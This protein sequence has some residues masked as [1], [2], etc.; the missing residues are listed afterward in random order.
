[1][2]GKLMANDASNEPA[3]SSGKG[4]GKAVDG[5][6]DGGA[7][8]SQPEPSLTE[9]VVNSATGLLRDTVGSSNGHVPG[10]IASSTSLGSK[11]QSSRSSGATGW[12][13]TGAV[14][15][16][17][18]TTA[19]QQESAKNESFRTA[20]NQSS[21]VEEFEQFLSS[22]PGSLD[23][24]AQLEQLSYPTE[25][26]GNNGFEV[27]HLHRPVSISSATSQQHSPAPI[28]F[29]DGAEVRDLLSDPAFDSAFNDDI[30]DRSAN[31][32]GV[33]Q[34]SVAVPLDDGAEVR[35]LLSEVI[36]ESAFEDGF[37]NDLGM[38]EHEAISMNSSIYSDL[39]REIIT[40]MKSGLPPPP[41][42]KDVPKNHPLNLRPLSGAEKESLSQDTEDY[43]QHLSTLVEGRAEIST[44]EIRED[45]LADWE[46]VLGSYSDQVWGDMLPTVKAAKSKLEEVRNG[47][48]PL[49][50]KTIARLKM[51]LGHVNQNGASPTSDSAF[52]RQRANKARGP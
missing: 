34:A 42:H 50:P 30:E 12:T 48:A 43:S 51:I 31:H 9:R 17:S 35:N 25:A 39:E 40:A 10:L 5:G 3:P 22:Q 28:A 36:T 16:T 29:D 6:V 2:F 11:A 37:N 13:E 8:T 18:G 52:A 46:D 24:G 47:T 45:W 21:T 14:R 15:T 27:D 33:S 20:Y 41:T 26:K 4:K 7:E 38:A 23:P 1:M 49:D 19:G 44:E 32:L